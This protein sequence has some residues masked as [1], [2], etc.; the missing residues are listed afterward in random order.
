MN[1]GNLVIYDNTGKIFSQTGEATGD[2]LPHVYP[3][4]L[5]YIEIPFGTMAIKRLINIDV[6]VTPHQPVFEDLTYVQTHTDR[7]AELENHLL[8]MADSLEGGIL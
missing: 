1:R 2:V 7:I 6:S 8:L 4:G 5:P 3:V